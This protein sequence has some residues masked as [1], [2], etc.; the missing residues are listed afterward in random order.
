MFETNRIQAAIAK[1]RV[2]IQERIKQGI[3]TEA[4]VEATRKSIG[5]DTGEFARFQELKSLAFAM[6]RLTLD[7]AS[8]VFQLLGSTPNVFNA[9]DVA[10]K[11]VLTRLFQE[12][13]QAQL[14]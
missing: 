14:A 10:T 11:A 3:T 6:D 1:M 5:I 12:L 2:Q 9:Q 4:K 13:L 7:D 8:L